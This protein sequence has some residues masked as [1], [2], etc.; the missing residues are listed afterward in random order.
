MQWGAAPQMRARTIARENSLKKYAAALAVSVLVFV[1]T[2]HK[3]RLSG[4]PEFKEKKA[5]EISKS[6][7]GSRFFC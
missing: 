5:K 1:A 2:S 6:R 3:Q 7:E 4:L